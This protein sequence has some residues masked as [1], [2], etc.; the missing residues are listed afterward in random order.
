V[1]PR[2]D[3]CPTNKSGES[4]TTKRKKE[5]KTTPLAPT[6]TKGLELKKTKCEE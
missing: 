2:S 1:I 4:T 3:H 6:T 5:K